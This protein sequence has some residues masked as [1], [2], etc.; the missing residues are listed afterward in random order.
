MSAQQNLLP[1]NASRKDAILPKSLHHWYRTISQCLSSYGCTIT[2]RYRNAIVCRYAYSIYLYSTF[3]GNTR[4]KCL[5]A[6]WKSKLLFKLLRRMYCMSLLM[7]IKVYHK[8]CWRVCYQVVF[9][10]FSNL[11]LFALQQPKTDLKRGDTAGG[12]ELQK[13]NSASGDD[14]ST[15]LDHIPDEESITVCMCTLHVCWCAVPSL[16][17]LSCFQYLSFVHHNGV[18]CVWVGVCV[19]RLGCN[20][21]AALLQ[22]LRIVDNVH[23]SLHCML[24]H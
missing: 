14:A 18:L 12:V 13:T 3:T 2:V 9:I 6:Y 7:C 15:G 8:Y 20:P 21:S 19:L 24:L 22:Q 16:S 10:G 5:Q 1:E 17:V 11:N 23:R 4:W